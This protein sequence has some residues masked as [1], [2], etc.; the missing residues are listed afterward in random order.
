MDAITLLRTDHRSVEKLFKRFEKAGE[1]ALV[2]KRTIVDQIVEQL[3]VHAA[4]EEQVFY[5][6]CRATVPGVEDLTLES[7]EEH[8]VVKWLLAEL[9]GLD[10]ESERFEAKTTVLIEMVRHHVEEEESDL[11]PKVRSAL[12][13]RPLSDLGAALAEAKTTAPTKPHPRSP[14]TPQAGGALAGAV[15]GALDRMSDNVSGVAQ[16]TVTALQDLIARIL[17][18]SRPNSSPTGSKR[19]RARADQVRQAATEATDGLAQT[20]RTAAAGADETRRAASSGA[21]ATRTTAKKS[22]RATSA[23]A[24]RSTTRTTNAARRA[25]SATA[26]SAKTGAK[27]TAA[28][29]RG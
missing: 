22:A 4:I 11:F 13:R 15:A 14:D 12:G 26:S 20:V 24:K 19:T 16:G 6:V 17:G 5:P 1:R 10:V 27:K 28:A 9:D 7:L 23:S 21:K 18:T 3:S 25:T 29:A 2:E 8:H